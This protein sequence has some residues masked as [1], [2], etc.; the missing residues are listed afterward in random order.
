MLGEGDREGWLPQ[1]ETWWFKKD[2][3][4]I[5]SNYCLCCSQE[6][7][8]SRVFSN[9]SISV[10]PVPLKWSFGAGALEGWFELGKISEAGRRR[11]CFSS[12]L[13]IHKHSLLQESGA[14]P[15]LQPTWRPWA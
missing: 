6:G 11:T 3:A 5:P 13:H 7:S 14:P 8:G 12:L 4:K 2:V 1:P 9:S 15:P 10:Q